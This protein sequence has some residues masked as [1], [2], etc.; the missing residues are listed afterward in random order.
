MPKNPYDME[1]E[2]TER[3]KEVLLTGEI[4]DIQ[5]Y[6]SAGLLTSDSGLVVQLKD[7]R[8]FQVTVKLKNQ[9]IYQLSVIQSN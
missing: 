3:L 5:N 6:K 2:F 1:N 4:T 9:E 8:E 7:G